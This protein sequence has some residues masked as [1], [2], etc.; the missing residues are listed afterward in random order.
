MTV[1]FLSIL[2]FAFGYLLNM[3]FI[4][5]LYH[6]GLAHNAVELSPTLR[7][8][9]IYGGNWVTGLDPKAWSVMHRMHHLYSDLEEDPHSPVHQGI[10]GVL[11][12]QLKSYEKTI[13][14]LIKKDP[15]YTEVAKDLNFDVNW[16]NR[17]KLWYL[18][19]F[20]HLALAFVI[21]FYTNSF[22]I[23]YAYLLGIMSH[24]IQGWMVN[25]FA[26][27]FGYR[28]YEVPDNSRNNT[29][30][31]WLVMGEGLQNNHHYNPS[32]AKFSHRKSEV[33][34]GYL[35]C[36]ITQAF[37]GLKIRNVH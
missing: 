21:G 14:G 30:V 7:K 10:F 25:S 35:L 1:I 23:G 4:T 29:L 8:A 3:F 13:R 26:H 5:V 6:R 27:K 32:S 36:L 24:P 34:T 19:Y 20:A 31:S 2:I 28:N 11:Y 12:G 37:G 9:V 18:P 22:W 17:N 33:D 15:T 16:L